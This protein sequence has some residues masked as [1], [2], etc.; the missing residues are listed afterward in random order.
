M[1]KPACPNLRDLFGTR[2]RT[3][4]EPPAVRWSDP[5]YHRIPCAHGHIYPHGPGT[6]A[7][8]SARRGQ[9]MARVLQVPGARLEQDAEDGANISF[10]VVGFPAVAAI[11]RPRRRRRLSDERRRQAIEQLRAFREKSALARGKTDLERSQTDL[12][13]SEHQ[14]PSQMR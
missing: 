13:E 12:D 7:W 6:L 10:P 2:Y 3:V 9:L 4:L 8:S 5:W 1:P 11:V 14:T